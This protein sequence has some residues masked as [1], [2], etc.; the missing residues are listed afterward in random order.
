VIAD[1]AERLQET[2]HEH[3]VDFVVDFVDRA[4]P[5]DQDEVVSW[6][7]L[8]IAEAAHDRACNPGSSAIASPEQMQRYALRLAVVAGSIAD[9]DD[10]WRPQTDLL[11]LAVRLVSAAAE[12]LPDMPVPRNSSQLDSALGEENSPYSAF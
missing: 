5:E 11:L 8:Q 3:G 9:E 12:E 1:C 10:A 7:E 6:R 2:A 4:G